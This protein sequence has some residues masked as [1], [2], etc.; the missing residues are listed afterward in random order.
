MLL[1]HLWNLRL[2]EA[3]EGAAKAA[4][5]SRTIE[6][7]V[8]LIMVGEDC[9]LQRDSR[10]EKVSIFIN[11]CSRRFRSINGVLRSVVFGCVLGGV[12]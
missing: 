8:E 12:V 10:Q 4:E 9:R 11:E 1:R 6:K 2:Q 3:E 7:R 5:A